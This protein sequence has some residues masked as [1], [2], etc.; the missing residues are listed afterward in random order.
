MSIEVPYI[1]IL[2]I[3]HLEAARE[4]KFIKFTLEKYRG[5]T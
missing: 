5:T 1:S 2:Q 3:H 4:K